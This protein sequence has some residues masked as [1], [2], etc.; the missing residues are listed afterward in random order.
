MESEVGWEEAEPTS[1]VFT[2][3]FP[4][5]VKGD[6][7]EELLLFEDVN[8]PG[9]ALE[10]LE[11][12]EANL[13]AME[14]DTSSKLTVLEGDLVGEEALLRALEGKKVLAEQG[15]EPEEEIV[16]AALQ[17]VEQVNKVG[18]LRLTLEEL[19]RSLSLTRSQLAAVGREISVERAA[20][21]ERARFEAHR[22]T[23][24]PAAPFRFDLVTRGVRIRSYRSAGVIAEEVDFRAWIVVPTPLRPW[25]GGGD[26]KD[27]CMYK[28]T[29]EALEF[30]PS[31]DPMLA[32][33]MLDITLLLDK[34]EVIV[35][36]AQYQ[37][38]L[39][40]IMGNCAEPWAVC[41]PLLEWARPDPDVE[42]GVCRDPLKG[43]LTA[44]V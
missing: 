15:D 34:F 22:P 36:R 12:R 2:G 43:R 37:T 10:L 32:R 4:H 9:K 5:E 25:C 44:Q 6:E 21:E 14:A 31:R 1:F 24:V 20:A 29:W 16:G 3:I 8:Q 7:E 41:P 39:A 42:E 11:A 30:L 38:I 23:R 40:I 35:S 28:E 26:D 33:E 19:H 17:I 13:V 27:S 18:D